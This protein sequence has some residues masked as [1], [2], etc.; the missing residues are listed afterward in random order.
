MEKTKY[1]K[2]DGAFSLIYIVLMFF[3]YCGL[4]IHY[5][6]LDYAGTEVLDEYLLISQLIFCAIFLMIIGIYMKIR[7]QKLSSV[8]WTKDNLKQSFFLGL[9]YSLVFLVIFTGIHLIKG[10]LTPQKDIYEILYKIIYFLV[11]VAFFEEI[12][13]RG[14][15]N[16]RMKGL[17]KNK[18]LSLVV[19]AICFSLMHFP[20]HAMNF[21][22]GMWGYI[23]RN[24]GYHLI[25]CFVHLI[26]QYFFDQ[27]SNLLAPVIMHFSFDFVQWLFVGVN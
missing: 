25:L 9:F 15:I 27:H 12:V 10:D 2:I 13:F 17:I 23:V 24:F 3:G 21:E 19:T 22:N 6:E 16:S 8:G 7:K 4:L 18:T 5:I 1:D 11:I 20:F 14:F 26:F